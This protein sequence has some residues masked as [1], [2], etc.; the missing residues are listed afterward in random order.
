MSKAWR[1]PL[2]RTYEDPVSHSKKRGGHH[3]SPWGTQIQGQGWDRP[4]DRGDMVGDITGELKLGS[5]RLPL[6]A[7]PEK[8]LEAV[9][10]WEM[11]PGG[12]VSEEP[13]ARSWETGKT[14]ARSAEPLG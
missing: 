13:G 5:A 3:Q 8:S 6:T 11:C 1:Q 14:K 2:R 7:E 10:D 9:V 12:R 4:L